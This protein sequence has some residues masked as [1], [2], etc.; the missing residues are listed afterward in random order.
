M[1]NGVVCHGGGLQ[2][3]EGTWVSV[4]IS[5]AGSA[6][7]ASTSLR[8]GWSPYSCPLRCREAIWKAS[9]FSLNFWKTVFVVYSPSVTAYFFQGFTGAVPLSSSLHGLGGRGCWHACVCLFSLAALRFSLCRCCYSA[10][11]SGLA[12]CDSTDCSAPGF[13]CHLRELAQ[14]HVHW[15]GDAIQPSPPLLSPSPAFNLSQHQGLFWW[16]RSSYQVPKVVEL[17]LQH[18]SF[19][20]IFML[21][22]P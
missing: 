10:S 8:P 20:W 3:L 19:Q 13:L 21:A 22:F 16:V 5:Q 6:S 12:L 18:Q 4:N 1:A 15:V 11:Q 17:Q 9:L 14:T 2:A 7:S